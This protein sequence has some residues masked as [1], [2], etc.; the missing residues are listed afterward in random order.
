MKNSRLEQS[1]INDW[2]YSVDRWLLGVFILLLFIGVILIFSAGPVVSARM[3]LSPY[4]F[5]IRQLL[6]LPVGLMLM[7]GVSMLNARE[8]RKTC[9][10]L[11]ALFIFLTFVTI[12]LGHGVKGAKRWIRVVGFTLQP[13]EFLKPTFIIVSAWLFSQ[14][15]MDRLF[16]GHWIVFTLYAIIVV[17]L[18]LQPDF[19]MTFVVSMVWCLQFF[20]AGLPLM[21]AFIVGG[22]FLV[23]GFLAFKFMPH[24]H[25]RVMGFLNG[26]GYQVVKAKLAFANGRLTGTGPGEGVFK[27]QIPDTHTDFIFAVWA[28]EFGLLMVLFLMGLFCFIMIRVYTIALK[29]KDFF[30]FL[31]LSGLCTEFGLQA[32]IN[33]ASAMN[34][35]P[36]KGMTLP[37]ISYGGSSTLSTALTAGLILALSKKIIGGK[38]L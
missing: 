19:G 37:L 1:L 36:P 2:W 25:V 12:F 4:H 34:L 8:V 17:L 10:I 27:H 20:L 29:E 16:P 15:R 9:L 3:G 32:G 31:A 26:Q 22:F 5:V 33:M 7:L 38:Y 18:L 35:I 6:F 28:E 14:W 24:V 11:L 23:G 13:S 30:N 21:F